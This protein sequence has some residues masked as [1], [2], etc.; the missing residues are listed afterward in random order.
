MVLVPIFWSDHFVA[1]IR[2]ANASLLLEL[3]E[4]GDFPCYFCGPFGLIYRIVHIQA[5][6]LVTKKMA[7]SVFSFTFF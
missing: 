2:R 6:D 4:I 3:S 7:E 1:D 5:P